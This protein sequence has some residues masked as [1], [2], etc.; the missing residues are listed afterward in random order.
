MPN[1]E[2]ETAQRRR[3]RPTIAAIEDAALDL[4]LDRGYEHVT[5][6]MICAAAGVSQRT[7]FNHFPTKGDALL[8]LEHPRLDEHAARRFVIGKGSLLSDAIALIYL[9]PPDAEPPRLRERMRVIASIP[10]LFA[11]HL[12]R[13]SAVEAD[14]REIVELR[15]KSQHPDRSQAE[16]EAEAAMVTD[17]LAGIMR[18]VMN[19]AGSEAEPQV[20]D[21]VDCAR[22]VLAVVL[23]DSTPE[24][25]TL[26]AARLPQP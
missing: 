19:S 1:P 7:F 24:P 26:P 18:F 13:M 23:A 14:I 4:A 25:E 10:S 20:R 5:V 8:G 6:D 9:P 21:R 12:E 2:M 16:C 11:R 22:A 17:L 3:A 15:I